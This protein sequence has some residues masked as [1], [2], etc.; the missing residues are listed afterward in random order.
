[1]IKLSDQTKNYA[2][3]ISDI[4]NLQNTDM[5]DIN[6][7]LNS[8]SA[9]TMIVKVNGNNFSYFFIN[10]GDILVIDTETQIADGMRV[11]ISVNGELSI[12]IF[13]TINNISY[14][15]TPDQ[16]F[17]PLS[18]KPYIEYKIIGVISGIIHSRYG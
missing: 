7:Y 14:I 17:L 2:G 4:S 11:L 9:S 8:N 16:K 18:I 15:Q 1:M 13:R 5:V 12:R 6:Q 3:E 10:D